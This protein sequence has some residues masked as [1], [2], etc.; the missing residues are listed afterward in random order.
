MLSTSLLPGGVGGQWHRTAAAHDTADR[1]LSR[2]TRSQVGSWSKGEQG[3]DHLRTVG[4]YLNAQAPWPAAG[5]ICS[6][7][8]R[9][10]MRDCKP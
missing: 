6:G 8:K 7:S 2:N 10:R 9:A 3:L 1:T 5:S 4:A